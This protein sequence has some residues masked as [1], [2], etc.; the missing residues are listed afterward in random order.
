MKPEDMSAAEL[1]EAGFYQTSSK[2]RSLARIPNNRP[3]L[4]VLRELAPYAYER[5]T[6]QAEKSARATLL[7]VYNRDMITVEVSIETFSQFK[8]LGGPVA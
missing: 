7:R 4:D 8:K 6:Q 1:I 2:T 5:I 3:P